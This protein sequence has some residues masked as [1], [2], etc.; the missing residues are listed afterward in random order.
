M[1]AVNLVIPEPIRHRLRPTVRYVRDLRRK[2][3]RYYVLPLVLPVAHRFKGALESLSFRPREFGSQ[4][5]IRYTYYCEIKRWISEGLVMDGDQTRIIEFGGSNG[6]IPAMFS[7]ANYTVAPNWPE[8]D[9]Q[10]L[11]QYEADTF[12]IV[13]I[14]QILE[15]VADPKKAVSEIRRVLKSGGVCV[16]ATPFLIRIHGHYGDYWRF[17]ELGLKQVFS[18]YSK[19]EVFAWGNR[20]TIATTLY[21]GWLDCWET[22]R[23]LRAALH[24]E[25]QWPIH[26]LTRA[27]K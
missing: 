7:K 25:S 15:H 26:F 16:C 2:A 13:I 8:V 4:Q 19:I 9:I 27:V 18:E 11:R 6:V 24:N 10:D 17:T 12:D 23:R 3:M 20:R 14:D 5:F 22:R 1:K 21:L